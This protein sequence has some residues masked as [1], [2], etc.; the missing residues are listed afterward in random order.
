MTV[1]YGEALSAELDPDRDLLGN[2][3]TQRPCVRQQAVLWKIHVAPHE[4]EGT[5]NHFVED[6]GAANIAAMDDM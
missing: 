6:F 4:G 1:K 5:T 3:Q 2:R